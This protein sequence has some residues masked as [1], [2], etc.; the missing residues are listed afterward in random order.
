MK[1][2]LRLGLLAAAVA[3]GFWLW[4]ILFPSAEKV[5][6]QRMTALAQTVTFDA[7]ANNISRAT[8][9]LNFIGYFSRD[10][11]IYVDLPGL[12]THTFTGR[13]EI[14]ETANSGFATIPGL[15]TSFL[16]QTI[17]VGADQQTAEVACTVRVLLGGDK[18]SGFEEMHFQW[19]KTDGVWLIRRAET[20]K[21]L[22]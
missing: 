4:T 13:D 14:R 3:V 20:V 21:T 16:D 8:K 2:A 15:K 10:A 1:I 12:G 17:R 6:H 7:Q 9:A 22:K 19:V 5:I 18:D 11:E